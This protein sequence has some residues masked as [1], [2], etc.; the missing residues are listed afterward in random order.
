MP[1]TDSGTGNKNKIK[2]TKQQQ[3]EST[4]APKSPIVVL[5][6]DALGDKLTLPHN[7]TT[8]PSSHAP[9]CIGSSIKSHNLMKPDHTQD[10]NEHFQAARKEC[11][12]HRPH[13][14]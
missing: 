1:S 13:N 14:D 2:F 10:G 8:P 6:K 7:F 11:D 3:S 4:A 9:L 5:Y 12:A